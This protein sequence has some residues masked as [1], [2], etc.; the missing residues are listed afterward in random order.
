MREGEVRFL[1]PLQ[2]AGVVAGTGA[3]G[4]HG[5]GVMPFLAQLAEQQGSQNCFS[6]AGAGACNE[7]DSAHR[8]RFL[9]GLAVA[10]VFLHGGA[11]DF[12][13]GRGLEHEIIGAGKIAAPA[14][15]LQF[16]EG[17]HHGGHAA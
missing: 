17:R 11:D 15:F 7:Q 4:F 8:E 14:A 9:G 3:E 16:T 2:Q 12:E 13:I 1:E 5:Q 10:Q 6:D